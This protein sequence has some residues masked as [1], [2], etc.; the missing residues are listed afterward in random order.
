MGNK[1][2]TK[3]LKEAVEADF[4][5]DMYRSKAFNGPSSEDCDQ[6]FIDIDLKD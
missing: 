3:Q 4:N 1:E 2:I 6:F 5:G